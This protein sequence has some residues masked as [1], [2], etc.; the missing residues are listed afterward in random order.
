MT[1][2][3][4]YRVGTTALSIQYF[5]PVGYGQSARSSGGALVYV[6]QWIFYS[7]PPWDIILTLGWDSFRPLKYYRS[8]SR[9]RASDRHSVPQI[10]DHT[11]GP[12]RNIYC[13]GAIKLVSGREILQ[14]RTGSLVDAVFGS[15]TLSTRAFE[16]CGF[17]L[18]GLA[19]SCL[20][21]SPL[22]KSIRKRHCAQS[23]SLRGGASRK[24]L[25]VCKGKLAHWLSRTMKVELHEQRECRSKD[26][27]SC[28]PWGGWY[29][30]RS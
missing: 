20:H 24:V 10:K 1:M 8:R 27:V 6:C 25:G 23:K 26:F 3:S 14:S 9:V 16:L 15:W 4:A 28:C 19:I 2:G 30:E 11:V 12:S 13:S 5:Y 21:D 22:K 18:F 29:E 17:A 7:R